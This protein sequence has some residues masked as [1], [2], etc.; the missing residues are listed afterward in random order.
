M[1]TAITA[2]QMF[3]RVAG[4]AMLLLGVL[5]WTRTALGLIPLHMWLGLGLVLALWALAG[6]A[7]RAGVSW[8]LVALGVVWGLVVPALGMMQTRLLPGS[9][10]WVIQV[11]HLVVGLAALAL[12]ESLATRAKRA[13]DAAPVVRLA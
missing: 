11:L 4:V 9:F 12:A 5:F 1:K 2:I 8:V 10:H 3:V 6:L 13:V 7:A